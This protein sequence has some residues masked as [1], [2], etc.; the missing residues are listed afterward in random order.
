MTT[1]T[2]QLTVSAAAAVPQYLA[3]MVDWE[4]RS[5]TP[6]QGAT[7]ARETFPAKWRD[8]TLTFP[9][10]SDPG[11]FDND[12][13]NMKVFNNQS[14]AVYDSTRNRLVYH[15]G[16]H[17][18]TCNNSI[19]T[20]DFNGD[21]APFGW[22]HIA[23]ADSEEAN[24]N[25]PPTASSPYIPYSGP[26]ADGVT[27]S[28]KPIAVHTYH[29]HVF[30]PSRNRYY[31]FGGASFGA[32]GGVLASFY[33]DFNSSSWMQI[34]AMDGV[35]TQ[36]G[37]WAQLAPDESKVFVWNPYTN[38]HYFVGLADDP[39][40]H[41]LAMAAGSPG[42]AQYQP[43]GARNLDFPA[44]YLVLGGGTGTG[45]EVGVG[46]RFARTEVINWTDNTVTTTTATISGPDYTEYSAYGASMFYDKGNSCF[47]VYGAKHEVYQTGVNTLSYMWK[48]TRVSA[49]SYSL[50]K[51]ALVNPLTICPAPATVYH[52]DSTFSKHVWFE[53]WRT[54]MVG[55]H[56]HLP[57][58]AL[59][60][61]I[62]A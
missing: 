59:R 33:W 44:E 30:V 4:I 16:G 28:L 24:I 31:R 41:T 2:F 53:D 47:W 38:G 26:N 57:M 7:T 54:L 51:V 15:G 21:T 58:Q 61:P 35:T 52:P 29:Q 48:I 32:G 42:Q 34:P 60:I 50:E 43:C 12:T 20:F 13:K 45:N 18:A 46:A 25:Y 37:A 9:G 3:G 56:T 6:W 62:G 40:A 55:C 23:G 22:T 39:E 49:A 11:P 10:A 8:G 36:V 27:G 19:L 17:A 5:L 1:R 14:G